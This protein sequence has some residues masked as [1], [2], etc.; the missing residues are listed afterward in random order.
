M[1]QWRRQ[2][3][4][5]VLV[6]LSVLCVWPVAAKEERFTTG[7]WPT[8]V[9]DHEPVKAGEHPRLVFR[10]SDVPEL[11]KRAQTPEGKAMIERLRELLGGGESMPLFYNENKPVN[12]G[13]K[14]PGQLPIDSYTLWHGAGFGLLYQL[15]GEQKYA[16]LGRKCTEK[17]LEG[18]PDRDERYGFRHPGGQLRAGPS[19]RAVALAYDLC[20]DGWDEAFRKKVA[21]EIQDYNTKAE[22]DFDASGITMQKLAAG[23]RHHPQSNHWGMQV[24]GAVVALLAIKGDPGVDDDKVSKWLEGGKE[25]L[26][27]SMTEGHGTSGFY[28]EGHHTGRMTANGIMPAFQALRLVEGED[29]VTHCPAVQMLLTKWAWELIRN[30][31]R[32]LDTLM[33]HRYAYNGF[34][35]K[36]MHSRDFAQGFAIT[37]DRYKPAM[38]WVF[39]HVVQPGEKKDYDVTDYPHN[40]VYALANWPIGLK[41]QHPGE[42][43]PPVFRDELCNYYVFR[44]G[45]SENGQDII[46]TAHMGGG[47]YGAYGA[48]RG[49]PVMF[50]GHGLRGEFPG[51]FW[52]SSTSYFRHADDGSAILSSIRIYTHLAV[53][54][55]KASGADCVIA[56]IG[57]GVG[58]SESVK[59]G[60]SVNGKTGASAVCQRIVADGLEW[61]VMTIQRG[62]APAIETD[63]KGLVIGK[64]RLGYNGKHIT[65]AVF[66]DGP[67]PYDPGGEY[68][69]EFVGQPIPEGKLFDAPSQT[70][71]IAK[72]FEGVQK[73]VDE[74]RY[75]RAQQRLADIIDNYPDAEEAAKAKD[76]MRRYEFVEIKTLLEKGRKKEGQDR[77]RVFVGKYPKSD[78]AAEAR[79][80]LE[81]L[82]TEQLLEGF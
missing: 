24:G 32:G 7:D 1:R 57:R 68:Y 5:P 41:E 17:A 60:T 36:G 38:L 18:V 31:D 72:L 10:K 43:L 78:E 15:T 64:Q 21:M 50:A 44:N 62:E 6:L 40:A 73:Q 20:Y 55:S 29:W 28:P 37:P 81:E 33:R 27:R 59:P 67:D 3:R 54:Y 42:V 47:R 35:R 12:T 76:M 61:Y 69:T 26:A 9:A 48:G 25:N 49:G 51:G 52:Q 23:P 34:N 66:G 63:G 13:A 79:K 58:T 2:W 39:N 56:M 82:E 53:D 16:D 4:Q 74:G 65:L 70:D 75:D 11:R 71:V 45:W 46:V 8:K 14:G 22:A 30:G 77:L 80:M 19:V